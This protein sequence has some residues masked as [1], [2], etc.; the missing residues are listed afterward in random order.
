MVMNQ[1]HM[2]VD[3]MSVIMSDTKSTHSAREQLRSRE[4]TQ[5]ENFMLPQ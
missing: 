2:A 3:Q 4:L 1:M 5:Q